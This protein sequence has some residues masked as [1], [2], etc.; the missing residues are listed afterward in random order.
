MFKHQHL[1]ICGL[2]LNKYLIFTHL[3]LWIAVARHNF[4][5][6]KIW[7]GLKIK[8]DNWVKSAKRYHLI[9]T[10]YGWSHTCDYN[11]VSY[12]YSPDG[13][14]S[15]K[16]VPTTRTVLWPVGYHGLLLW[17]D[18]SPRVLSLP[19]PSEILLYADTWIFDIN[20][21]LILGWIWL[22]VWLNLTA[23]NERE[24]Q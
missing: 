22:G 11:A 23:V 15:R 9:I 8:Y 14:G 5:W 21:R 18:C 12:Q 2:K 13:R 16:H 10:H 7:V 20:N 17:R 4:K 3:R 1:Q 6:V 24:I 19:E